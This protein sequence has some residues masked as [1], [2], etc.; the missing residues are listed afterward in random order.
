MKRFANVVPMICL[1]AATLSAAG[2]G[3][4]SKKAQAEEQEPATESVVYFTRDISPAGL[5]RVYEALGRKAEGRVAIKISTGEPGGHNY[6]KPEL[7]GDLVRTTGGTIVECNTAYGGRR[8]STEEHL[9]AAEEHGFTAIAR[10]DIM[11]AEGDMRIPVRDTTHIKYDLV[12]S[13][14]ADYDFMINLAHFKGH[15]M[16]GFGGVLKNQSIGVASAAGKAY[17]HTAGKT[18]DVAQLWQ[19]I[20]EQ[21][22]FLESMAAAAQ[23]VA[24]VFGDRIIYINVLNNLSVDCDCDSSP[25][26]P[27]M[28][29]IGIMASIDPVA[30]DQASV[31]MVYASPEE[32]KSH[33]IERMESRHGIHTVEHAAKIGLGSREYRLVDL[34]AR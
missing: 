21:D 14:L 23:G 6:L 26:D 3:S 10:V 16:G 1:T 22:A 8:S 32:G 17:I 15:A 9:K 11:D 33:L 25:E 29:D 18:A 24:D 34:D 31:D 4:S 19:N 12:G 27:R 30:L 20:A 5:M 7:I 28:S 2:C 13:H